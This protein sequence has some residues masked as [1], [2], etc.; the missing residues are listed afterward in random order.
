L[1]LGGA[2]AWEEATEW[3][4]R[5][6]DLSRRAPIFV[7]MLAWCQAASGRHELA[8]Q[9]LGEL[10][11]R[12]PNE[13]VSPIFLAF[14]LSELGEIAD[15]EKMRALLGE[16]FAE[17]SSMLAIRWMPHLRQLESEPLMESLRRRLL[18]E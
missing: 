16:A 10:E 9:T 2:S 7:G 13:Y 3:F 17:R 14:P 1:A 11:R 5:A 18:G 12:S 4:S 6:V 8:R 15:R